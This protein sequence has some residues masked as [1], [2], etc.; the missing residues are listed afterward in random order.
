MVHPS[1]FATTDGLYWF[2]FPFHIDIINI[3]VFLLS[4]FCFFI[5][6]RIVQQFPYWFPTWSYSKAYKKLSKPHQVEWNSRIISTIH[7]I[8]S[9]WTGYVCTMVHPDSIQ[10]HIDPWEAVLGVVPFRNYALMIT[11]GYLFYDFVLC[12]HHRELG[13]QLVFIHHLLILCAFALGVCTTVGT[14]YMGCLLLN[15]ASTP[16]V[17]FNF[18]MACANKQNTLC[19]KLNGALLW[20]SFFIFRLILC[21]YLCYLI[22]FRAWYPLFDFIDFRFGPKIWLPV[23]YGLTLLLLGHMTLNVIWFSQISTAVLRKLRRP[24]VTQTHYVASP[25]QRDKGSAPRKYTK[26]MNVAVGEIVEYANGAQAVKRP[27]GRFQFFKGGKNA[28]DLRG[29]RSRSIKRN[30]KGL[31]GD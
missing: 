11:S 18:F 15:E 9:L 4:A 25:G 3:I 7:A 14:F 31:F 2:P 28:S 16:F 24:I 21:I 29:R 30:S 19:Y 10:G 13:D 23:L 12:L 26:G 1:E 6:Y 8:L 5:L 22:F 17:N 27:N 20:L